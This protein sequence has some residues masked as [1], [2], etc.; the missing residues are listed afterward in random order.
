MSQSDLISPLRFLGRLPQHLPR[1]PRL[2]RGLYY[3]GIRN[4][5]KNLSLAWALERTA[6]Q[7]PERP[8]LLDENRQLSYAQ[9]NTWANRLAWAFKAEGV[10][11]GSVV[12][13]ML[14][15]RLELLAI[16]AALSKLGAVGGLVN[17]TQRGKV[18]AHSLNLVNPSLI[19][20]GD[21]LLEA[22]NEVAGLLENPQTPRY[23]IADR[24]C[25]ADAG[26]AP[27]GWSNLLR[28]AQSQA[29]GN[30]PDSAQEI[31]RASC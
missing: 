14:E 6:Q 23:W 15:N 12:A 1:L 8:A 17:S 18:L 26:V 20:V 7:H 29:A 22:F 5:E 3:V 31:G 28:L 16:L 2:L 10:R 13:V 19:L 24:D 11:H 27:D 30:P 9:F 4:R 21:E 25:L